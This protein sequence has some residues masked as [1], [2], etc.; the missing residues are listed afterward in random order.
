MKIK[1]LERGIKPSTANSRCAGM[2]FYLPEDIVVEPHDISKVSLRI[3]VNFSNND[4]G[5]SNEPKCMVL[6]NR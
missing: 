5:K 6:E 2:D 3:C 1:I 4:G